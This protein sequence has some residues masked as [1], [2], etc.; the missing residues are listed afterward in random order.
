VGSLIAS[1]LRAIGHRRRFDAYRAETR[2]AYFDYRRMID[3][4]R[5]A[6]AGLPAG[7]V[8]A[9]ASKGDDGLVRFDGRTGWH[10]P[11]TPAGVYAGHHP[12]EDAVAGHLEDLRRR[13]ARYSCCRP[14]C[15]GGWGITPT[16]RG[17]LSVQ[18]RLIRRD[19]ACAVYELLPAGPARPPS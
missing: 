10:F 6:A 11:Q 12:A 8:V 7:S 4:V 13:G 3:A 15:S 19:D 14:P 5:G 17:L 9:V 2:A 1:R 16:W 18:H